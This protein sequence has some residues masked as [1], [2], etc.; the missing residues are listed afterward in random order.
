MR[1]DMVLTFCMS[2]LQK[3]FAMLEQVLRSVLT[4][5]KKLTPITNAVVKKIRNKFAKKLDLSPPLWYVFVLQRR[6]FL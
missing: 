5:A 2:R 3:L 1:M 4:G 6:Q